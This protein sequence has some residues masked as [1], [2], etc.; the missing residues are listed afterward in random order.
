MALSTFSTFYFGHEINSQNLNLPFNEGS[1]EVNAQLSIKSYSLSEF[2]TELQSA[3]NTASTTVNFTV[4]VN[5]T[6]RLITISGDASFDLLIGTGSTTGS[7]VFELAGFTGS[8]DLT[9]LSSYTGDSGS[10]FR[11]D[12][13]F[14]LQSFV[15][16]EDFQEFI[17]PSINESS[18]GVLEIIR[19]G[20]RQFYEFDI[21]FITNLAMDGKVIKNNPNGLDDAREFLQSITKRTRFE[22]MKNINSPNTFDKVV[23]ESIS[24]NQTATGYKLKELFN[25]NLPN[26]Y[27][28]GI[29]K[30]RVVT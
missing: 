26:I 1:G 21:K 27:E 12:P 4:S 25:Q 24:G 19:F 5:R 6:T 3:L 14:I 7:S 28:T 22:F 15:D 20:T 30:L 2:V 17:D 29:L 11:Y 10:G 13:Q 8:S 9:G 18:S 16:K 23:L